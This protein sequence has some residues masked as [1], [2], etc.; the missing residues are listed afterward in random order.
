MGEN[1][2][3]HL[4]GGNF[5]TI[6]TKCCPLI[7]QSVEFSDPQMSFLLSVGNN[8]LHILFIV[9]QEWGLQ[10]NNACDCFLRA[11]MVFQQGDYY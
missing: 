11:Q 1:N 2:K 10:I 9:W 3:E 8:S 6:E 7:S 5:E 4:G